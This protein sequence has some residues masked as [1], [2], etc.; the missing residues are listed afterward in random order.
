MR[1]VKYGETSLIVTVFTELFG[2]QSYMVNGVRS[3]KKS[4]SVSI[5]H[6]Q[7]G[8]LLDM[9]VYHHEK[10]TLQRIKDCRL[11]FHGLNLDENMSRNAVLLFI[12]E[13]LQKCLKQP[14]PHPELFYFL[15]DV[16]A[17][18]NDASP[19][20]TANLPLFFMIHLSHFFGF[21]LMDNFSATHP[22]L[23]L[24]E[25]Q[26]V[27]NVPIHN[28]YFEK[29]G[30]KLVAGMLRVMQITELEQFHLNR[31]MRNELIDRLSDFYALHVQPFG[32][33]K[34]LPVLRTL[35]AD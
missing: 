13:L 4:Q 27:E 16:M 34:S 12:V 28:L 19:I 14:D 30:S 31:Q 33:L 8:N 25:G 7:P 5:G 2:V 32:S 22:L 18:L 26:F 20:Q 35:W 29:S 9:V 10:A 15:E 11:I 21:R 24:H 1:T 6:L 23:D 3:V 17:G